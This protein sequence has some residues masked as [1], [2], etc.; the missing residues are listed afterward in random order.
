M[1]KIGSTLVVLGLF[2]IVLNF[3]NMVPRVLIWI[4]SWGEGTAWGIKIGLIVLG[5]VLYILGSRSE[6]EE[7]EED[8]AHE[9]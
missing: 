3:L 4:Y 7:D 1:K 5:A 2:A 6:E 8:Y 9:N